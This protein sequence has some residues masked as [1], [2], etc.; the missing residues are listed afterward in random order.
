MHIKFLPFL[1]DPI[2]KEPLVY[3]GDAAIDGVIQEGFLVS[4]TGRYPVIRGVPRFVPKE[5]YADSF[6][7]QWNRWARVQFDSENIGKPMEGHTGRMWRTICGLDDGANDAALDGKL[8]LDIGCGPGR[9]IEVARK[10]GA[11]VI[12]IDYSIAADAAARNFKNDNDVCIVQGDAL[13]LPFAEEIF[14]A[15]FSIGVLHHTPNP[16][17]G[18]IEAYRILK[19]NGWLAISVYGKSGYYKYPNVQAWRKVFA[20]LWPYFSY[21]PALIYTYVTVTLFG[22]LASMSRTLGRLCKIPFPFISMPDRDWSLLDTFDSVTP[23]YQS[24]HESYEV[25]SWFK[26]AGYRDIEPTN[27]G[28]TSWRGVKLPAPPNNSAH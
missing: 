11:L 23:S 8:V 3:E 27:W 4:S 6:G 5:N 25:F 26:N 13:N 16:A 10:K 14:D 12:G 28:S 7:W 24:G 19:R 18:G 22:P 2:T 15:A 21:R 17:G 20:A 1:V 9:F